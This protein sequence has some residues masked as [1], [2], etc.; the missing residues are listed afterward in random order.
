MLRGHLFWL[1][2][3][4]REIRGKPKTEVGQLGT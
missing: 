1:T 3:N 4:V 2:G